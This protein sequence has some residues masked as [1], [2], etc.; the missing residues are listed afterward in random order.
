MRIGFVGLGDQGAPM[1]RAIAAAGWPLAVWARRPESFEAL[2]GVAHERCATLGELADRSD[3]V[4]LCVRSD[5]DVAAVLDKGGLLAQLA[6]GSVVANHGTG[7]PALAAALAERWQRC[8]IS[9]LD[10]PVSGGGDGARQRT[11]TVMVGGDREAYERSR[12]V[13]ASFARSIEHL[14]PAGSGQVAK[15]LNNALYAANLRN[16]GELLALAEGLGLEVRRLAELV[17]TS[18]GA[19]FA[20]DA[21]CHRIAPD[22]VEGYQALVGKDLAHFAEVASAAALARSPLQDAADAGIAGLGAA[23]GRLRAESEG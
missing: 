13:F 18:S 11:L 19:S 7:S 22:Q 4:G 9:I 5:D 1:A 23:V 21:L 14:G 12:P 2:A 10:A 8:G 17:L 16:A 20:L 3:L 6:P 15:L